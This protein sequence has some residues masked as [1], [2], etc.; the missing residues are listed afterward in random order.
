[1]GWCEVVVPS[2]KWEKRKEGKKRKE[3]KGL[4]VLRMY[5]QYHLFVLIQQKN[6]ELGVTYYPYESSSKLHRSSTSPDLHIIL[7]ILSKAPV[8]V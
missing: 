6:L 8:F 1:M 7:K 5:L 2:S 3:R 4:D